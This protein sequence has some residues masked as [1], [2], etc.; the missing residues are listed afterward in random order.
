VGARRLL[1]SDDELLAEWEDLVESKSILEDASDVLAKEHQEVF[2][3]EARVERALTSLLNRRGT[4]LGDDDWERPKV[5][6]RVRRMLRARYE[7]VLRGIEALNINLYAQ[8]EAEDVVTFSKRRMD[9]LR[10]Q[11]EELRRQREAAMAAIQREVVE[12]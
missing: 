12:A 2:A 9:L 10:P 8:G 4:F 3:E 6:S 5:Y 1:M 11:L 7:Y